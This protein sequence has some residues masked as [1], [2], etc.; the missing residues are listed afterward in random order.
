MALCG[1]TLIMR[2]WEAIILI[3]PAIPQ[4]APVTVTFMLLAALVFIAVILWWAFQIALANDGRLFRS[5]G[6]HTRAGAGAR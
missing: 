5:L 6:S 2:C 3:L 4:T 1:L